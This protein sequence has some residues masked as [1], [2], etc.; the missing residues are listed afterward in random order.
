MKIPVADPMTNPTKS[1]LLK[2]ANMNP[3]RNPFTKLMDLTEEN[4]STFS[5]FSGLRLSILLTK[6]AHAKLPREY[7]CNKILSYLLK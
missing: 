4:N 7:Q 2:L 1:D 3:V 5:I 6:E